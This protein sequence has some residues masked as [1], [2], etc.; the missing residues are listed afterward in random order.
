VWHVLVADEPKGISTGQPVKVQGLTAMTWEIDGRHGVS[1]R[2]DGMEAAGGA[3]K[4]VS[5]A[6]RSPGFETLVE[7]QAGS[8]AAPG[9]A[10]VG[11]PE[12]APP[13]LNRHYRAPVAGVWYMRAFLLYCAVIGGLCLLDNHS[14]A[15]GWALAIVYYPFLA[16]SRP[17]CNGSIATQGSM[18]LR[19][20]CGSCTA[21]ARP[22]FDGSRSRSSS[23]RGPD[24]GAKCSS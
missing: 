13:A 23:T 18:N 1:F 16:A 6:T 4:S 21:W 8:S 22:R 14:G 7:D 24:Q 17:G 5:S 10:T 11:C 12:M 9:V 2:V 19:T 3:P 20:G 15:P